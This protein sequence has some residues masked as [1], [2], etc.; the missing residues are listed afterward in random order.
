MMYRLIGGM[1]VC[2]HSTIQYNAAKHC[3]SLG[4]KHLDVVLNE[5]GFFD[6]KV[7]SKCNH[8]EDNGAMN[9]ILINHSSQ[10]GR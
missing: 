10:I 3:L 2:D 5:K 4:L 6:Q 8:V 1:F 9:Y 7:H